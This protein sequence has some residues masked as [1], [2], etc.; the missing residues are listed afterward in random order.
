M[1]CEL[2][3]VCVGRFVDTFETVLFAIGREPLTKELN[4]E[5]AGVKLA[6]DGKI[7]SVTS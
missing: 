2:S 4:L 1:I 5:A 3:M 7:W 6:P